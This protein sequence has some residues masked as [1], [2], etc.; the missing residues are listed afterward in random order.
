M[1]QPY[2]PVGAV[3]ASVNRKW[4]TEP[5]AIADALDNMP[6]GSYKIINRAFNAFFTAI[7]T[8]NIIE[9]L[10]QFA[11]Y[12]DGFIREALRI[13]SR[14]EQSFSL[15]PGTVTE[16]APSMNCEAKSNT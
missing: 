8:N 15:G 10:H 3:T 11:R 4:L 5:A 6:A 14:R 12:I 2:Y 16:C 13:G 9:R 1:T 7:T